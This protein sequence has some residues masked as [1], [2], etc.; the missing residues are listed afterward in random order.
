VRKAANRLRITA[1]LIEA[2][3]G[4]HLWADRFDG[5]LD[6]VF[7]LQDRITKTIVGIIEPNLRLTEIER[8]RR[9]RPTA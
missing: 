4:A 7:E 2:D 5:A 6:D 8:A 9:K 1:Q 3:T